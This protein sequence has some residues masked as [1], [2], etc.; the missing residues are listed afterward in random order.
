VIDAFA[1][2]YDDVGRL[3]TETSTLGPARTYDYFADGQVQSNGSDNFDW[4]ANGNDTEHTIDPGNV[5]AS[6]GAWEYTTDDEGNIADKEKIS[7]GE[8]W[9]YEYD[10][11][12]R[13]VLAEH[14]DDAESAVDLRVEFAYDILGNRIKKMVDADGD[15]GGSATTTKFAYDLDGNAIADLTAGGSLITRRIYNDAVDAL[16]ARIDDGSGDVAYYLTDNIGSVRDLIDDAGAAFD[17][18]DYATFGKL[19]NETDTGSDRYL[20]TSREYDV[21]LDLQYNRAR[22][23]DANTGRWI[24]QDPLG[25]DAGDSNLYRYVNNGPTGASDPSGLQPSGQAVWDFIKDWRYTIGITGAVFT[26]SYLNVPKWWAGGIY[27]QAA[28]NWGPV[29]GENM[30]AI[31][32]IFTRLF[33]GI[34]GHRIGTK[35]EWLGSKRL[36]RWLHHNL[37]TVRLG[38]VVGRVGQRVLPIV[39]LPLIAADLLEITGIGPA[40]NGWIDENIGVADKKLAAD[41]WRALGKALGPNQAAA[42]EPVPM[43][44]PPAKAPPIPIVRNVELGIVFK[45]GAP[46]PR[47]TLQT[48]EYDHLQSLSYADFQR[49]YPGLVAQQQKIHVFGWTDEKGVFRHAH[50]NAGLL[51][52]IKK[53]N[54]TYDKK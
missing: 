49:Q 50:D 25:F 36:A 13:L 15:G 40:I 26:A 18:L 17:H 29:A 11:N 12:N 41:I 2:T 5:L 38:S 34:A 22:Y 30:T 10:N 1:Y 54:G 3:A 33:P 52:I 8:L 27:A 39:G 7:N 9:H 28:V 14:K 43:M 51:E 16:Y 48:I 37:R 4:D 44:I 23:Y 31:N 47:I 19:T 35:F 21:E 20:Y 24:S 45:P 46:R 6:D 53:N 42:G 32:A